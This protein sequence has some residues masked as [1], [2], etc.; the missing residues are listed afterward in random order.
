MTERQRTHTSSFGASRREAHDASDFY[1]RFHPPE[2]SD[3]DTVA[4]APD[5]G[6]G[7]LLGDAR[8]MD[9]LPDN[10]VALVITSPPYFAGKEYEAEIGRDGIPGSYMEYLEMLREV[11]AE[12]VRVL[13]PGGRIAVNVANLGRKPY[14]SLS[15]DVIGILQDDLGLLL[16]GEVVWRKA[17][18]MSGSCAWGSFRSATNPVLR[19]TTER[20]VIASKGRFDRARSERRRADEGLPSQS[21]LSTDEFL[22]ATLDVWEIP[23]ESAQ[24]IG[25]PAPF[26]VALPE[27]LINLYSFE[28]DVVLDPFMG[29]GTTLVAAA[30][31]GRR[32]VGYDLDPAYIDIARERLSEPPGDLF[33]PF[34]KKILDIAIEALTSAGFS[35]EGINKKVA[36]VTVPIIA[37]DPNDARWFVD[38]TGGLSVTPGGLATSDGV[39]RSLGKAA[40]LAGASTSILLL[41]SHLPQ[42]A[43]EAGRLLK[44]TRG[45][46]FVEAL[47]VADEATP[48]VLRA[49]AHR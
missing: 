30:R 28:G 9:E 38:V 41:T 32:G 3:D 20:I 37:R 36:G 19:D 48:A 35:I 18:G 7:C 44:E 34:D 8:S 5:L 14:R 11:F 13:E 24:R 23:S 46:L 6:D 43:T 42:P 45:R 2:I 17:R 10:S 33:P 25:H 49:L 29:S 47:E 21:T 15:S 27:R 40:I 1:A 22:E 16:R 4:E 39:L 12:C 31:T 26:P